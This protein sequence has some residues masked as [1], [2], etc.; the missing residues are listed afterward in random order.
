MGT[1]GIDFYVRLTRSGMRVQCRKAKRNKVIF[2]HRLVK[3]E[4]TSGDSLQKFESEKMHFEL[5]E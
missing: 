4:A 1:Y 3:V 2:K 5:L